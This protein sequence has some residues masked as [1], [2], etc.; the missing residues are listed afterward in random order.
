LKNGSF[1]STV[2]VNDW[3]GEA[4]T[5]EVGVIQRATARIGGKIESAILE[6]VG[7]VEFDQLDGSPLLRQLYRV[8]RTGW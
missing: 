4:G 2:Q 3:D 5:I 1:T 8:G 7:S 6:G